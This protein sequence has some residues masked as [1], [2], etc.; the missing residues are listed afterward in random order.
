[1]RRG[2]QQGVVFQLDGDPKEM[3]YEESS[4]DE[5]DFYQQAHVIE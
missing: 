4:T 2:R 1:M 3:E 5:P